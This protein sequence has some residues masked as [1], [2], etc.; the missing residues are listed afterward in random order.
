MMT[1]AG[2]SIPIP[3]P[4]GEGTQ[5]TPRVSRTAKMTPIM[6]A[7]TSAPT[8]PGGN[9]LRPF[10]R[11]SA[12]PAHFREIGELSPACSPTIPYVLRSSGYV[13]ETAAA[14]IGV[15]MSCMIVRY[16]GVDPIMYPA[17]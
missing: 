4:V 12:K 11:I 6:E 15:A 2:T 3:M 14:P 10:E 8:A 5:F 7:I 1:A 13:H 17:L 16:F 9:A